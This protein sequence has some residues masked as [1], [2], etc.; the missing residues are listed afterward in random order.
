MDEVR[1]RVVISGQVQ[2]VF[3]RASTQQEA[4]KRHLK[5]WVRNL[6]SGQVEAIFQGKSPD[7]EKIVEWCH[8]GPPAAKVSDVALTWEA[9]NPSEACFQILYV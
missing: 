9:P 8:Q 3:F 7:V 6:G 2:G 5:G 1:V 4:E